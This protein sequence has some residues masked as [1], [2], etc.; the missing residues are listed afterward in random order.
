L[1]YP[2]GRLSDRIGRRIPVVLGSLVYGLTVIAVYLAPTVPA[3]GA[4][5]VV[6]GIFGALVAPAT[7]ALVSDMASETQRGTAMGGFNVFGSLG[8]LAG[9]VGG[10]TVAATYGFGVAFVAVGATEILIALVAAP[11]LL[12]GDAVAQR[13]SDEKA[14]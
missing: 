14:V 9:I 5:M 11:L 13:D 2:F 8:F 10:A 7:M 3:T 12:E 1:Q 4:A 6:V